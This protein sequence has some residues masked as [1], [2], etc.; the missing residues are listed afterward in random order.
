MKIAL[1]HHHLSEPTHGRDPQSPLPVEE[2]GEMDFLSV[3]Q[4]GMIKVQVFQ[5]VGALVVMRHAIERIDPHGLLTG[6]YHIQPVPIAIPRQRD[7]G[8]EARSLVR[9]RVI[10]QQVRRP[11]GL[12]PHGT[13]LLFLHPLYPVADYPRC[14]ARVIGFELPLVRRGD[15]DSVLFRG[16]HQPIVGQLED[17]YNR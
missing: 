13:R 2:D 1:G 17:A 10:T 4:L 7:T 8:S 6:I 5:S 12:Y 3:P 15:K 16:E 14:R 11:G 9:Q